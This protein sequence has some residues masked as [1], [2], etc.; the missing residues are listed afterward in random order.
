MKYYKRL[1]G[2]KGSICDAEYC[3]NDDCL[4][5]AATI[6]YDRLAELGGKR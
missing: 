3:E 4:S 2:E 6:N 5:C 1:T